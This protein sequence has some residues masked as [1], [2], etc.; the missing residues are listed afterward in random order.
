MAS[1]INAS[2][3]TM[4]LPLLCK[5]QPKSKMVTKPHPPIM[6]ASTLASLCSPPAEWTRK[7]VQPLCKVKLLRGNEGEQ[8]SSSTPSSV[9]PA[10]HPFAAIAA[11][12]TALATITNLMAP[13]AIILFS[14]SALTAP[15]ACSALDSTCA[16]NIDRLPADPDT[17]LDK[18]LC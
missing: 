12:K 2:T 8:A 17:Y 13:S 6:P 11:E 15:A 5:P 9:S 7:A 3:Q 16:A 14:D 1:T 4:T 18:V 10:D